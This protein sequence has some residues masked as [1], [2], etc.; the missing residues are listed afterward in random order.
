MASPTA[1]NHAMLS[2]SGP[3]V[4]ARGRSQPTNYQLHLKQNVVY[5]WALDSCCTR[6][7]QWVLLKSHFIPF[8]STT[9]QILEHVQEM[10][11]NLSCLCCTFSYPLNNPWRPTAVPVVFPG[12]NTGGVGSYIYEK[13]PSAVTQPWTLCPLSLIPLLYTTPWPSTT[14]LFVALSLLPTCAFIPET[15]SLPLQ[16]PFIFL[17]DNFFSNTRNDFKNR[18][19]I[20]CMC[21][22]QESPQHNHTLH[23]HT[24]AIGYYTPFK[25]FQPIFAVFTHLYVSA[26]TLDVT[27]EKQKGLIFQFCKTENGVI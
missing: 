9:Q 27:T 16:I 21:L 17:P 11:C 22:L 2:S 18:P 7:T 5:V 4:T 15:T 19:D 1:T 13:E 6:C 26:N 10:F 3:K 12:V 24:I 20:C 14:V 23:S 25:W 8:L